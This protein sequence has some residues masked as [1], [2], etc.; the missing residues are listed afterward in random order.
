MGEVGRQIEDYLRGDCW[1]SGGWN[2]NCMEVG[3]YL[4]HY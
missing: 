4:Y 3:V 2:L 1:E